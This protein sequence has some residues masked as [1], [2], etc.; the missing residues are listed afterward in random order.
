[1]YLVGGNWHESS[2]GR[3]GPGHYMKPWRIPQT[4]TGRERDTYR[5]RS[6]TME[7]RGKRQGAKPGGMDVLFRNRG[8]LRMSHRQNSNALVEKKRVY[9]PV[10]SWAGT[11]Q[12]ENA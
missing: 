2:V 11:E 10:A 7:P 3:E 5:T 8:S 4:V 12:G 1:M 6:V 9:S